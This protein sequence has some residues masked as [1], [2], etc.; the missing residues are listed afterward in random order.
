MLYH[1]AVLIMSRPDEP[2]HPISLEGVIA[3]NQKVNK[4]TNTFRRITQDLSNGLF[5]I[6]KTQWV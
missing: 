6:K 4:N 3:P 1:H 2:A 5:T